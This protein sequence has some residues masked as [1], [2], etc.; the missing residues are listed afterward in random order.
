MPIDGAEVKGLLETQR[1]L[2]QAAA[3]LH[4]EPLR[5]GMREA[6]LRVQRAAQEEVPVD[7]ARLKNSITSRVIGESK[8]VSGVVGTKVKYAARV[9]FGDG[10]HEPE[11]G[12]LGQWARRNGADVNA[13]ANKI[14]ASGTRAQPYMQPAAKAQEGAVVKIIENSVKGIVD[15]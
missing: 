15:Q 3:D 8:S 11:M 1:K 10:P 5:Q 14:R 13:V 12:P 4:G 7:T 2:E 9:E 6:T